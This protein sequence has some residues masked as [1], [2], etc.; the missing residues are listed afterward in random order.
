M[1]IF[2]NKITSWMW[3]EMESHFLPGWRYFHVF[4]FTMN[5]TA[6]RP[7]VQLFVSI[8]GGWVEA[9]SSIPLKGSFTRVVQMEGERKFSLNTCS[10]EGQS[11]QDDTRKGFSKNEFKQ[12]KSKAQL[13]RMPTSPEDQQRHSGWSLHKVALGVLIFHLQLNTAPGSPSFSLAWQRFSSLSLHIWSLTL[14]CWVLGH[15]LVVL[16]S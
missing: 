10:Q 1:K 13:K 15:G 14:G 8:S 11:I 7:V 12:W 4:T 6:L 2:K 5:Y 3:N 16:L 9:E